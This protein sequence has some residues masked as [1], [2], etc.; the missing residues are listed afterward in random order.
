MYRMKWCGMYWLKWGIFIMV[1]MII[2]ERVNGLWELFFG[3]WRKVYS[4]YKEGLFSVGWF[5]KKID[6]LDKFF[7]FFLKNG[8]KWSI[9]GIKIK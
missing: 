4:E 8:R 9:I 7:K 2:F 5:F 3:F 6:E 1:N